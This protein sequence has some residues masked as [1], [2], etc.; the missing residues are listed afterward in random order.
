MRCIKSTN[1]SATHWVTDE[2]LKPVAVKRWNIM[3][4]SSLGI[5]TQL[6]LQHSIWHVSVKVND[7]TVIA[8][9]ARR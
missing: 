9:M 2:E 8:E 5:L 3:A 4:H 1:L 7:N 6:N